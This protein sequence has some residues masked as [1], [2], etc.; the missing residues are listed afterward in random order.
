MTKVSESIVNKFKL[1]NDL[2]FRNNSIKLKISKIEDEICHLRSVVLDN[3]KVKS[4]KVVSSV[5][6]EVVRKE[7]IIRNLK[8]EYLANKR[9]VEEID[10]LLSYVD[11]DESKIITLR[12][13]KKID[14][15]NVG[16]ELSLS[17]RTC[18]RK[19]NS[20]LVKLENIES[21]Y[22]CVQ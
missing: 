14:W 10:M 22:F 11:E 13:F 20:A 19:L 9:E 7:V 18:I 21:G 8:I 15:E 12:Y 3:C 16:I 5:E 4:N 1:Y 2:K 6:S 17:T